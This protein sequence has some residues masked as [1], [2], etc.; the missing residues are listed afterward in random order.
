MAGFRDRGPRKRSRH[1]V[2]Q[3]DRAKA[4]QGVPWGRRSRS[5]V[6]NAGCSGVAAGAPEPA[7]RPP[8]ELKS[9]RP[10]GTWP[11][12]HQAR[13]RTPHRCPPQEPAGGPA[14]WSRSGT[15][16][17]TSTCESTQSPASAPT[18]AG[19]PGRGDRLRL[20][21]NGRFPRRPPGR[22]GGVFTRAEWPP[23]PRRGGRWAHETASNSRSPCPPG[24]RTPPR[25]APHRARRRCPP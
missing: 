4:R 7:P 8:L 11:V 25:K 17:R 16:A 6:R 3:P 18:S 22:W 2:E 21:R 23:G 24:G 13:P 14:A 1:Y 19:A 20:D 15:T 10:P 5:L 9:R 12:R